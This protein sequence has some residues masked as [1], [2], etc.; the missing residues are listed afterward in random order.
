MAQKKLLFF[1]V[2]MLFSSSI[3]AAE[4]RFDLKEDDMEFA[5][6]LSK[7]A[8]QM[9]L[10]AIKEK[11]L[12]LQNMLT[13]GKGEGAA[14]IKT[15]ACFDDRLE[16]AKSFRIFVSS[17]M[18]K[19]LLKSYALEAKKYNAVLVFRG[20]PSGSWRKLSELINEISG[21]DADSFAASIDD[22]AFTQ[23]DIRQVPSFVLSK[24]EDIFSE[25]P[26]VTFDKVSGAV[27]IRRAL[28]LFAEK[29][30]L[31]DIASSLLEEGRGE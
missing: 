29:G 14:D 24:E 31:K 1:V 25:N 18:S 15:P 30:E 11:W 9:T 7:E 28:E 4:K 8:R 12:E 23:F 5:K 27:G 13:G 19:N 26:K 16:F 2:L 3:R 6:R 20:L 22:E 17:S 21:D 10:P